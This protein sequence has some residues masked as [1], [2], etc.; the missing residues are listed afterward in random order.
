MSG[1]RAGAF[2]DNPDIGR[3]CPRADFHH[4][5]PGPQNPPTR[6]GP[7]QAREASTGSNRSKRHRDYRPPFFCLA[8]LSLTALL[9]VVALAGAIGV[10][11]AIKSALGLARHG[12]ADH[13]WHS[14]AGEAHPL[15]L[16]EGQQVGFADNLNGRLPRC[17]F[18]S[19][20]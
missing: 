9:G 1:T 17:V 8:L 16:V 15:D 5:G 18:Q 12:A 6:A 10:L 4:N 7:L 2:Y 19:P 11:G 13:P 3:H 20:F 14:I